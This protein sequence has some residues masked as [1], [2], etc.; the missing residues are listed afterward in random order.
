MKQRLVFMHKT[1]LDKP[2]P[3]KYQFED[4]FHDDFQSELTRPVVRE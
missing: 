3:R 4:L 2:L 1:M